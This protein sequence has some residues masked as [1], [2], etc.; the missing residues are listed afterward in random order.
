[1][2][3]PKT[4]QELVDHIT[5]L[6]MDDPSLQQANDLY[7]RAVQGRSLDDDVSDTEAYW[8]AYSTRLLELVL[9]AATTW[10]F[11]PKQ[12]EVVF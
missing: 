2:N 4:D 8:D 1:M 11:A 12:E 6:V 3:V 7:V 10:H 9:R 5:R